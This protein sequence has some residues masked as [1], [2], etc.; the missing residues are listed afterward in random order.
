MC[1][2]CIIVLFSNVSYAKTLLHTDQG[3]NIYSQDGFWCN[4]IV[5]LKAEIGEIKLDYSSPHTLPY[6]DPIYKT[7]VKA[8]DYCKEKFNIEVKQVYTS[9]FNLVNTFGREE[10]KFKYLLLYNPKGF[11]NSPDDLYSTKDLRFFFLDIPAELNDE[12]RASILADVDLTNI[13]NM[14]KEFGTYEYRLCAGMRGWMSNLDS[15]IQGV[16]NRW[17]EFSK[18][19]LQSFYK[20]A[21]FTKYFT[22]PIEDFTVEQ[23]RKFDEAMQAC[24]LNQESPLFLF[25]IFNPD[26][27]AI[28]AMDLNS[29]LKN[30]IKDRILGTGAHFM[31]VAYTSKSIEE[32]RELAQQ[33]LEWFE[34]NNYGCTYDS[35]YR[36]PLANP[37]KFTRKL[38]PN[39][40]SAN[41]LI[42]EGECDR[43]R[44]AFFKKGVKTFVPFSN[45]GKSVKLRIPNVGFATKSESW[46]YPRE[47]YLS[48]QANPFYI[49]AKENIRFRIMYFLPKSDIRPGEEVSCKL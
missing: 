47:E 17:N 30:A 34:K 33:S 10:L 46:R 41:L 18:E 5:R 2:V 43:V 21:H 35:G 26:N 6:Q 16:P 14:Q 23:A 7:S 4:K 29:K 12:K 15:I 38:P 44:Y 39:T 42:C 31:D 11:I 22:L 1:L 24:S 8:V 9:R 49:D 13:P 40:D 27:P 19:D 32:Q 37:A 3:V 25:K 28:L 20:K 48:I 45:D 36:F